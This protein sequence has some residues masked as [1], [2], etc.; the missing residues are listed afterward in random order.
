MKTQSIGGIPGF[1][2]DAPVII[3]GGG[4]C[5]TLFDVEKLLSNIDLHAIEFGSITEKERLGNPGTRIFDSDE[6]FTVNSVGMQN[7]GSIKYRTILG[8]IIS[9]VHA[10]G[11]KLIVNVAGVDSLQEYVNLVKLCHIV[12]ADGIVLNFGCPNVLDDGAQHSILSFDPQNLEKVLEMI[13]QELGSKLTLPV[14]A[15][16]SPL[17]V[18]PSTIREIR[19]NEPLAL[20]VE[21]DTLL[22]GDITNILARHSFIKGVVCTNTIG[23]VRVL[24]RDG[25]MVIG[26]NPNNPKGIAGLAGRALH[27]IALEQTKM[28]RSRLPEYVDIISAGG[29]YTGEDVLAFENADAK[30]VQVVSAY[31]AAKYNPGIFSQIAAERMMLESL[32]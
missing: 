31:F 3:S 8:D 17:I 11:K 20:N 18:A 4:I 23:N 32:G 12:G 7:L 30:G 2:T 9:K 25:M 6:R 27:P 5:K 22:L 24:D 14:W 16:I 10:K 29:V 1:P 13:E 26:I 15:K 28:F 21:L 19:T